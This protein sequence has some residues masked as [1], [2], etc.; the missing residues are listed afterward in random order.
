MFKCL[1]PSLDRFRRNDGGNAALIF[2]LAAVPIMALAGGTIDYTR[3]QEAIGRLQVALDS[4]TL[5]ASNANTTDEEQLREIVAQYVQS[6]FRNKGVLEFDLNEDLTIEIAQEG[7][8]QVL[9]TR[10]HARYKP[11]FLSLVLPGHEQDAD[12]SAEARHGS[13]G[14][15]IALVLDN[16]GSMEGSKMQELKEAATTMIGEIAQAARDTELERAHVGIVPYNVYVNV[17]LDNFSADWLDTGNIGWRWWTWNGLVGMRSE[18]RDIMDDAYDEEG[19]PAVRNWFWYDDGGYWLRVGTVPRIQPLQDVTDEDNEQALVDT[20]NSM[21]PFS[22]TN[23]PLGLVWGWRLLTPQAPYTEAMD[24]DQARQ[25]NV[26]KVIVLMTDGWNSCFSADYYGYVSCRGGLGPVAPEADARMRQLCTNIK[27]AG[28][29]IVTVGY[30]VPQG[31]STEQLLQECQN[32][33]Y[34]R[35]EVGELV[36][37]FRQIANDVTRLHLSG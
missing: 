3:K 28:I 2:A 8:R 11:L 33:G 14:F 31:S 25:K 1:F 6:N 18:P 37:I 27:Q 24:M 13:S 32:M 4:A 29:G 26:R 9:R 7:T 20:V 30:D 10:I 35:A 34:Y 16:T 19:I 12:V 5:A 23:I 21:N 36:D 22:G 15:E 17:G